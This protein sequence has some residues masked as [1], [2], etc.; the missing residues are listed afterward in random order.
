MGRDDPAGWTL[1]AGEAPDAAVLADLELAWSV[2]KHVKSNAIVLT[3]DGH[4]VGV[5][6]GQQN[7]VDAARIAVEKAG[8][9]AAGAAAGS[10]AFFPFPDGLETL[11]AAGVRAVAQPGGSRRDEEV[12]SAA[13][14]AGL[15]MLHTHR[16]HFRH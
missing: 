14:K 2:A 9:R 10:D 15:T 1:V 11:A 12:T 8:D 7:R 3:R 5:G 4:V 13:I 16:R 6:A